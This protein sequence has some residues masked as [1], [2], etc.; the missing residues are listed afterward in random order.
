MT[1]SAVITLSVSTP[2]AA[3][4]PQRGEAAERGLASGGQR[5]ILAPP[6]EPTAM[7]DAVSLA[8]LDGR[9]AQI[10]DE[11]KSFCFFFKKKRLLSV[12]F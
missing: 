8:I 9:L 1:G 10:A 6:Q 12:L 3:I 7:I 5:V 4:Y 11:E 2:A